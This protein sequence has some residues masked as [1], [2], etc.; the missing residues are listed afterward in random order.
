MF[1]GDPLDWKGDWQKHWQQTA[2]S[3][4]AV[5]SPPRRPQEP[6]IGKAE[7]AAL[8]KAGRK[9]GV[10]VLPSA[11]VSEETYAVPLEERDLP[12][13]M[14]KKRKLETTDGGNDPA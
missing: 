10:H 13:S 3:Q 1:E 11:L 8:R 5:E 12:P 9:G 7:S 2:A 6:N 4:P 14:R